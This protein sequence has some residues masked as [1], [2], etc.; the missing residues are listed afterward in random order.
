M[1]IQGFENLLA[2]LFFNDKKFS[3]G[4][5]QFLE[6]LEGRICSFEFKGDFEIEIY[7]ST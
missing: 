4:L 6:E 5:V 1:E 2:T 7:C 3:V